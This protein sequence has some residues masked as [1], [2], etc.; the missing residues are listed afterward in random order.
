MT[1][2]W[3]N[4]QAR[5][6]KRGSQ[7]NREIKVVSGRSARPKA[8]LFIEPDALDQLARQTEAIGL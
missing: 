1:C 2:P 5:T 4:C 8:F 3:S 7:V 6:G